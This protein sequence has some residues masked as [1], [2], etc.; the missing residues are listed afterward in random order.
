MALTGNGYAEIQRDRA[1]RDIAHWPLHPRMT[2]PK[3]NGANGELYDD[4]H[5]RRGAGP[6]SPDRSRGHDPAAFRCFASTASTACAPSSLP[7]KESGSPAPRRNTALAILATVPGPAAFS[8]RNLA[9][10]RMDLDAADEQMKKT[11]EETQGG[12]NQGRAAV[13]SGDWTLTGQ[14]ACRRSESQRPLLNAPVPRAELAALFRVPPHLVG[15]ITN[16]DVEQQRRATEPVLCH[17]YA[18]PLYLPD[19]AGDHPQ[20]AAEARPQRW[21]IPS[22]VRCIRAAARRFQDHHGWAGN[23]PAVGLLPH[24]RRQAETGDNPIDSRGRCLLWFRSTCKNR[25]AFA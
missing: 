14:S 8:P 7:G 4:D 11:W 15:D 2:T 3:R 12:D 21:D 19:R 13:P 23:G 22:R 5:R 25:K 17:R 9:A 6:R 10:V 1:G 20:A 24:Q 18:A 16:A